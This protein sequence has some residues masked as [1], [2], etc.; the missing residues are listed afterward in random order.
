MCCGES[1]I[2]YTWEL[3]DDGST[4]G[5]GKY[6]VSNSTRYINHVIDVEDDKNIVVKREESDYGQLFFC[7]KTIH[8]YI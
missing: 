6:R 2:V 3:V 4:E 8:W 1:S 7:V 5:V